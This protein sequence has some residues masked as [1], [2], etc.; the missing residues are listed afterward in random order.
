VETTITSE[1]VKTLLPM[2]PHING[3]LVEE[4]PDSIR[5]LL[6]L[7]GV[8]NRQQLERFVKS[9]DIF[10]FLAD[11]Y[12][13]ELSRPEAAPLDPMGVAIWCVILFTRG[14]Q[15]DIKSEI[16]KRIRESDEYKLKHSKLQSHT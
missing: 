13:R 1:D 4:D 11:V 9:K 10:D 3:S 2:V 7:L 8:R 6:I 12:I 16:I 5:S 15:D 14:L